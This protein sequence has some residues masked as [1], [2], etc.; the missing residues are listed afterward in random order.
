MKNT[1]DHITRQRQAHQAALLTLATPSTLAKLTNGKTDPGLA[2]WRKLRRIEA[3]MHKA[4]TD[5]C[6]GETSFDAL[7]AISDN[8]AARVAEIFGEIPDGFHINLDARGYAL[9]LDPER[10]ATLP[11][12]LQ[13]DWGGYGILAAEIA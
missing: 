7:R 8:T 10:G 9:K 4:A 12:G 6:N 3:T 13:K 1:P 5:W 2:L 11:E